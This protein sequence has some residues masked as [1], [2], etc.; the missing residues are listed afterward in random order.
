MVAAAALGRAIAGDQLRLRH[1]AAI[2][3]RNVVLIRAAGSYWWMVVSGIV[4]PLLYLLAMGWGVGSLVGGIPLAD[5]RVVPYQ[6][7]LAPALVAASAMNGTYAETT[8]NFFAKL[9]Y[10]RLYDSVL[11]TPVVPEEIAF[12]ELGWALMRASLYV[13]PFL[14]LMVVF[15]LTTPLLA[16]AALPAA[17]L[18]GFAFGGLGLALS[19]FMRSWQDFNYMGIAQ[20]TLFLFSG[21]FVPVTAF[22]AALRVVVQ[23]TPLYHG[24][25]LVRAITLAQP[26]WG[27]LWDVAY[28][29]VLSAVGL[30]V[31]SRRM[32]HLLWR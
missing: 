9:R 30:A 1:V 28:L 19:T 16:L 21:T 8:I 24:V 17:L 27:L 25:Q 15:R 14:L 20:F 4:E 6:A 31:A 10:V 23:L 3:E 22:P 7:F 18:A 32:R 2:T 26:S 13:G 29:V 12:G 11:N 5:G